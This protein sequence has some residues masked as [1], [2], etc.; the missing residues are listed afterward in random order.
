MSRSNE[1]PDYSGF[2]RRLARVG[3]T[4]GKRRTFDQGEFLYQRGEAGD[5]MFVIVE[6]KVE[7]RFP[8]G[9]PPR[10]L[11]PEDIFGLLALMIDHHEHTASAVAVTEVT[12]HAIDRASLDTFLIEEPEQGLE[13]LRLSASYMVQS[14]RRVV[15]ELRRRNGELERELAALKD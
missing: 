2:V 14:E 8:D 15:E 4:R 13:L 10:E 7:I 3:R 5:T 1:Q 12:A 6:G 11:G 9:R